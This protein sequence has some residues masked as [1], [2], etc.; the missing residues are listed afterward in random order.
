MVVDMI[1]LLK[2][3]IDVKFSNLWTL[4]DSFLAR[5]ANVTGDFRKYQNFL[6]AL[7]CVEVEMGLEAVEYVMCLVI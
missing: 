7:P 5:V 6:V 1:V 3:L 2:A 4:F